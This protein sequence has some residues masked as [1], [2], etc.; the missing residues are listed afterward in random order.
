MKTTT[1]LILTFL[2]LLVLGNLWMLASITQVKNEL[3]HIA[4]MIEHLDEEVDETHSGIDRLLKRNTVAQNVTQDN[5]ARGILETDSHDFGVITKEGGIVQTAFTVRNTGTDDLVF[6]DLTTSCGC[7]SA[8]LD[9][10]TVA[11]G[12]SAIL[13]INFD[14]NF[15]EEPKGQFKRHVYVPTNDPTNPELIATITVEIAE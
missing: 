8:N 4:E 6:G 15:H 12:S 9:K 11:P 13:T 10:T 2:V 1:T 7:T 14:P 3:P 5:D